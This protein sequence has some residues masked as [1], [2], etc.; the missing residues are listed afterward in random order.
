MKRKFVLVI[1]LLVLIISIGVVYAQQTGYFFDI[2]NS[3]A[4][5]NSVVTNSTVIENVAL[6]NGTL[7]LYINADNIST[8][9]I[10]GI[11]YTA[12]QPNPASGTPAVILTY[13]GENA[14]PEGLEGFPN[15][16]FD[17]FTNRS[18]P[19]FYYSWNLTFVNI[20]P[21]LGV[22]IPLE[23]ALQPLVSKY[24]Q[25]ATGYVNVPNAPYGTGNVTL[26]FDTTGFNGNL[27]KQCMVLF[28]Y[29]QLNSD[30]I[31]SL[32]EDLTALITPAII[33]WYA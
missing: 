27:K 18:E 21:V 3:N 30:Q 6:T 10:N 2:T 15:P 25:L 23:R 28:S 5:I 29:S 7:N 20:N 33:D 8:V 13:F 19:D 17:L 26:H 4:N 16:W 32:T 31:N 9:T 14:V 1:V 24:P 22:G 12:T 11:N